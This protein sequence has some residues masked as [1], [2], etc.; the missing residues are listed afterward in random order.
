MTA[1]R[2]LFR[3]AM[4]RSMPDEPSTSGPGS[5]PSSELSLAEEQEIFTRARIAR[6][7]HVVLSEE[8]WFC[9][10][11]E[12]TAAMELLE[13]EIEHYWQCLR[14]QLD[15]RNSEPESEHSLLNVHMMLAGFAIEN[16][17]KGHLVSQLS[18]KEGTDVKAGDL[19]KSLKGN[20][21]ILEFVERTG[22]TLSESEKNLLTRIGGAVWRGR[23]PIPTSHMK[24]GPFAQ[25]GS[26]IR[27]IKAVL[28]RLREHVGAK[29]S[30]RI[31]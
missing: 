6:F 29:E 14:A 16:L 2:F 19:P 17:C 5:F 1:S 9:V 30:Y 21:G 18:P 31:K 24:T 22:M 15:D 8:A 3:W 28:Q 4:F 25:A 11:N 12:L 13:P 7:S 27:E 20:H 10:A 26:D 23:Y